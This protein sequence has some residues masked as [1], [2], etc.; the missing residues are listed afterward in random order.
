MNVNG[1]YFANFGHTACVNQG[2]ME[3]KIMKIF[4]KRG[5]V[6]S[7]LAVFGLSMMPALSGS[8]EAKP[9][10]K[11]GGNPPGWSKGK[12]TGWDGRR[13]PGQSRNRRSNTRYDRRDD[14]RYDRRNDRRDDYRND[15]RY[16]DRYR[17]GTAGRQLVNTKYYSTR[18]GAQNAIEWARNAGQYATMSWDAN[19]RQYLV[20]YYR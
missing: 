14:R 11:H 4:S 6:L 19:R 7:A 9:K 12:K 8:A 10:G 16:R 13:P 18:E 1:S 17:D 15:T 5:V 3:V 20:R 2:V